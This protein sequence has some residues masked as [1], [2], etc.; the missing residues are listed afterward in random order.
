MRGSELVRE[1]YKGHLVRLR[2]S[3]RRADEAER[4]PIDTLGRWRLRRFV[5]GLT[6]RERGDRV[7]PRSRFPPKYPKRAKPKGA[8]SDERAKHMTRR[9]GLLQG[10][11]P[12]NRGLLGR[13]V[14]SAMGKPVGKTVGGCF[15]VVTRRIPC[16]RA[17][18][19][20]VNPRSAAGAKENRHG[21]EGSKPPRG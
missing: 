10:S 18:L 12:R 3:V 8:S 1:P 14:A 6:K 17:K 13:P 7:K 4:K 19:R 20:R 9:Q 5:V 11:K 21:T 16:E 15:Q 2:T